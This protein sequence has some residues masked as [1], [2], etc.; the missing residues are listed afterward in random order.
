VTE[1]SVAKFLAAVASVVLL[2]VEVLVE[3][4]QKYRGKTTTFFI[5]FKDASHKK[6][7]LK[8]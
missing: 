3:V 8:L 6:N 4:G 5:K 1:V 2:V 7:K